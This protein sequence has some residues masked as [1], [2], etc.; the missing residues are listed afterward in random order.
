MINGSLEILFNQYPVLKKAEIFIKNFTPATPDGRCAIEGD[1][2]FALV[3]RYSTRGEKE[4]L[5]ESHKL[6]SE[7]HILAQGTEIIGFTQEPLTVHTPYNSKT[8]LAF[9]NM[10]SVYTP[11]T[12][13]NETA[14]FFKAGEAHA[15]RIC[16]DNMPESVV[17]AVIKFSALLF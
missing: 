10:P 4:A 7:I 5:M 8:D 3:S 13:N 14:A 6:Y 1:N 15:P 11:L 2:V 9:W 17:K 12:V 16:A